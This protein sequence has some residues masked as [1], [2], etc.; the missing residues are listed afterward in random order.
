VSLQ[1]IAAA[2]AGIAAVSEASRTPQ[3]NNAD[4]NLTGSFTP[5]SLWTRTGEGTPEH[6]TR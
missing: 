2:S 5:L 4:V 1:E 3:A 6:Y